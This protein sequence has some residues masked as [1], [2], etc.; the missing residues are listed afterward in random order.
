M[1][2][3]KKANQWTIAKLESVGVNT[4]I[5]EQCEGRMK[6]RLNK[7]GGVPPNLLFINSILGIHKIMHRKCKLNYMET[8]RL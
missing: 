8:R 2:G 7:W 3:G 1:I 5:C 4:K 6:I